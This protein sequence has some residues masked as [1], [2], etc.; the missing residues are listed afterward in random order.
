MR[1]SDTHR[2]VKLP[3]KPVHKLNLQFEEFYTSQGIQV[4]L[5][6]ID[7]SVGKELGISDGD[8]C[9]SINGTRPRGQAHA[10]SLLDRAPADGHDR[11]IC[12]FKTYGL[13]R[14]GSPIIMLSGMALISILLIVYDRRFLGDSDEREL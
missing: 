4:T 14:W 13:H 3:L 12:V 5:C 10:L 9:T 8:I 1:W 2:T 7:G 6:N 11:H